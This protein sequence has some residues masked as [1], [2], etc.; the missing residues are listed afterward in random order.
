MANENSVRSTT[1]AT[2]QG[3]YSKQIARTFKTT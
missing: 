2:H 3:Y 1:S